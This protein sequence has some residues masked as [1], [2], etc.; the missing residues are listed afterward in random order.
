MKKSSSKNSEIVLASLL[1]EFVDAARQDGPVGAK[2]FV[3]SGAFDLFG[4]VR[5][6]ELNWHTRLFSPIKSHQFLALQR[7][8]LKSGPIVAG[9][10]RKLHVIEEMLAAIEFGR[11]EFLYLERV[12]LRLIRQAHGLTWQGFLSLLNT[13]AVTDVGGILRLR[14]PPMFLTFVLSTIQVLWSVTCAG[15][16]LLA[17]SN[18]FAVRCIT[19]ELLGFVLLAPIMIS[20]FGLFSVFGGTWRMSWKKLN[21]ILSVPAHSFPPY[22]VR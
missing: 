4:Y 15:L 10:W 9:E 21:S 22:Q 14:K 13:F 17:M 16:V 1:D 7:T 20:V 6:F 8:V 11:H 5:S 19:C 18:A 2:Q 3:D 12:R